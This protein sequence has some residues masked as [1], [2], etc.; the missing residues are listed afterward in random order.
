MQ[1]VSYESLSKY[2]FFPFHEKKKERVGRISNS[3]WLSMGDSN[4]GVGMALG[5]CEGKRLRYE[6]IL[7]SRT[8]FNYESNFQ[9]ALGRSA[10]DLKRIQ[11]NSS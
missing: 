3:F 1:A 8:D 2:I 11:S 9:V 10:Y 6:M 7:Q 5:G 4:E